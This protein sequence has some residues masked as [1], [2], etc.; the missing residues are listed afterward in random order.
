MIKEILIAVGVSALVLFPLYFLWKFI[1]Y[2]FRNFGL[3]WKYKGRDFTDEDVSFCAK[4]IETGRSENDIEM[5]LRMGGMSEKQI[6]EIKYIFNKVY[7]AMKGG[8]KNAKE[9]KLKG[10]TKE[11]SE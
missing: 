8:N 7:D 9:K 2:L 1:K 3:W 6:K 4:A 11:S 10:A 5:E